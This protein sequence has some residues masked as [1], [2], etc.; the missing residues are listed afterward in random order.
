VSGDDSGFYINKE[1]GFC[2]DDLHCLHL[3]NPEIA[4]EVD[5]ECHFHSRLNPDCASGKCGY[6]YC[7]AECDLSEQ[8]PG[9]FEPIEIEGTC[10]CK[11]T[12]SGDAQADEA[13]VV[14]HYAFDVWV[15]PEADFCKEDLYCYGGFISYPVGCNSLEDCDQTLNA[16]HCIDGDCLGSYCTPYCAEE[17]QCGRPGYSSTTIIDDVCICN[18]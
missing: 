13:C 4:C 7:A 16:S 2:K 5:G 14:F 10:Y 3:S 1:A 15:N 11:P 18:R 6:S 8:C 17:Q 9:G 12:V